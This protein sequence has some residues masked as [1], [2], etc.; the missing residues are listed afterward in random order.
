MKSLY[1]LLILALSLS[2][3]QQSTK[4]E[5]LISKYKL[6]PLSST[7]NASQ[8]MRALYLIQKGKIEEAI[9]AIMNEPP[10]ND[11]LEELGAKLIER[12]F[13]QNDLQEMLLS[14]YGVG[15][16]L[17]ERVLG[18]TQG[19]ILCNH[20]LIELAAIKVLDFYNTD[21]AN[22]L[23][24]K[25]LQ[26]DYLPIRL[27]AVYA[28]AKK[29]HPRAYA[30][31]EAL[32]AKVDY[33]FRPLFPELFAEIDTPE[34][35][36]Q[37]KKL[38]HDQ[39][40][41]VRL[42]ALLGSITLSS[43]Y[44]LDEITASFHDAS[45][46]I[47]EAACMAMGSVHSQAGRCLLEEQLHSP[48]PE[49]ALT[50]ATQLARY[51]SDSACE[52]IKQYAEKDNLFAIAALR[53]IATGDE[54]LYQKMH[55]ESLQVRINATKAL[56]SRQ[57]PRAL[58]GLPTWL[59]HTPQD[60]V[61]TQVLSP[62]Q[63]LSYYKATASA[64]EHFK[65]NGY[66]FEASLRLREECLASCSELPEEAFLEVARLIFASHQ[67]DLIPTLMQLLENIQTEEC[68][69]LLR[70]ESQRLGSPFIRAYAQ[71][72][73]FRLGTSG[74]YEDA[75]Y[76]WIKAHANCDMF[77]M[78]PL[79]PWQALLG[80]SQT[81]NRYTLTLQEQSRLLVESCQAVAQNQSQ[82][83]IQSLLLAIKDGNPK[84]RAL[85]A[86]LLMRAAQ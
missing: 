31:T 84:N 26:S 2:S 62:G 50:A 1:L 57:D 29:K 4:H 19:A 12:G 42:H 41:N 14:L 63:A 46:A 9:V 18:F 83:S 28:L 33:E 70:Q 75:V 45:P 86:G 74:P 25:A 3:C 6:E 16:A 60:L 24:E 10:S 78:R 59:L 54:L 40:P 39:D 21:G 43:G 32:F 27:E 34:A 30:H 49:V 35:L 65:D 56:L 64:L 44:F 15:L 51:G 55:S 66:Y 37:L 20:P 47:Q 71:L 69:Q 8:D 76:D 80:I 5:T 61:F 79:L 85:L 38:F 58:M 53:D 23:L 77:E 17:N 36:M 67:Y 13:A 72:A 22:A 11:V 73:L 82:K 7:S 52:I 48:Y 81:K 68:I